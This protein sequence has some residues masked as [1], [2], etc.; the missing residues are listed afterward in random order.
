[1]IRIP[2]HGSGAPKVHE[3][4]TVH[5]SCMLI[6]ELVPGKKKSKK[7]DKGFIDRGFSFKIK[8]TYI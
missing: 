3:F 2:R 6:L 7:R 8:R 5:L 1:M 4:W